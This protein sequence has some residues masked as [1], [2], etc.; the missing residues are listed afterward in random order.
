MHYPITLSNSLD[1]QLR[2]LLKLA[3]SD[4]ILAITAFG[5]TF[6]QGTSEGRT[7]HLLYSFTDGTRSDV[8][9]LIAEHGLPPVSLDLGD[10]WYQLSAQALLHADGLRLA[11]DEC[12]G[13]KQPIFEG[14]DYGPDNIEVVKIVAY[15]RSLLPK[16]QHTIINQ[17]H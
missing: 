16:L 7:R 13:F 4:K 17:G 11:E 8:T 14:G 12:F 15:Q 1:Q 10:E 2:T 9:E 5:D 3:P 6:I